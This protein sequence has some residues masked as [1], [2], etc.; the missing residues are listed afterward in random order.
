MAVDWSQFTPVEDQPAPAA[1]AVDWSKFTPVAPAFPAS[2]TD[3]FANTGNAPF[4]EAD[5]Q[6][7]NQPTQLG[8]AALQLSK[9][10]GVGMIPQLLGGL[11]GGEQVVRNALP[12]INA[13]PAAMHNPAGGLPDLYQN[14]VDPID[15]IRDVT[16]KVD[17][18]MAP[19]TKAGEIAAVPVDL[20]GRALQYAGEKT[21]SGTESLAKMFGASP[22][23]AA[24]FGAAGD[25]IAQLAAPLLLHAGLKGAKGIATNLRDANAVTRGGNAGIGGDLSTLPPA[26]TPPAPAQ[27]AEATLAKDVTDT[28]KTVAEAANVARG[29][30]P[31]QPPVAPVANGVPGPQAPT[32]AA[33]A[34]PDAAAAAQGAVA[35][36]PGA[37]LH[38]WTPVD[39]NAAVPLAGGIS[40]DAAGPRVVIDKRM[41]ATIHVEHE[42]KTVPVDAHEAVGV[43]ERTEYPLMHL[44]GPMTEADIAAL[45]Q[46]TGAD[47]KPEVVEKLKKGESLDYAQAHDIATGAE[48]AHIST[49][50]GIPPEKYQSALAEGIKTAREQAPSEEIPENLDRKPYEDDGKEHLLP[51]EQKVA[52]D[53]PKP[54]E[55]G[56][57]ITQRFEQKL[58]DYPAAKAEYAAHPETDG[59]SV[60]NTDI[61]RELSSDYVKDRTKSA[62]VHEP[63]SAFT[64]RLYADK[65]AEPTPAGKDREVLFTAGGTGAGKSTGLDSL[66]AA[67]EKPEIVYDTNMNKAESAVQK[68]DQALAAGRTVKI[69][70]TYRDPVEALRQGALKRAMRQEGEF[71]SGRSV[72]LDEHAKTHVGAAKVI[73]E[74]SEKYKDDKRVT[75][76]YL[77]NSRGKGNAA[78]VPLDKL[79]NVNENGLHEALAKTRDEAHAAGEISDAV[80][81]G[82]GGELPSGLRDEV[83]GALQ[84]Q[85]EAAQPGREESRVTPPQGPE[86]RASTP[87]DDA[88]ADGSPK[89]PSDGAPRSAPVESK[90]PEGI[91]IANKPTNADRLARGVEELVS[92]HGTTHAEVFKKA[93]DAAKTDSL[94]GQRVASEIMDGRRGVTREDVADLLVDRVRI[95][96][97]YDSAMKN[98][99]AATAR[100]D[101]GGRAAAMVHLDLL[102]EQLELNEQASRKAGTEASWALSSRRMIAQKD[103]T[104]ANQM[105]QAEIAAGKKSLSPKDA[106]AVK[107]HVAR[108]AELEKKLAAAMEKSKPERVARE[109]KPVEQRKREVVQKKV[110]KLRDQIAQRLKAC[111]L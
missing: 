87:P 18:A 11:A 71:G 3:R 53:S 63:A 4:T 50:Y 49:K 6:A 88:R 28:A 14:Q 75:F 24:G 1:G 110:D 13:I 99:D 102:S 9:L 90:P 105:R 38:P 107:D 44:T 30:S 7:T 12:D 106:Q 65:L 80:H 67:G 83:P 52:S 76:K 47:L 86:A 21:G 42:G 43:H 81:R 64:K 109:R 5:A 48:N 22:E 70:Y 31:A 40:E 78:F 37:P 46:R 104:L 79:P 39:T 72:P 25:T 74:L 85:G 61:A 77:D 55:N 26:E 17:T 8:D 45:A 62:D 34:T 95:S 19:Q 60:I 111:P 33:A 101:E 97:E 91:S 27:A 51:D 66:K 16:E 103:Y 68:I 58:A 2:I 92:E 82:F 108:I 23:T 59:G 89:S 32:P 84:R 100:N 10:F 56:N 93:V 15:R 20:A 36:A 41:P 94:R 54:L 96:N 57:P 29:E 69:L 35:P 98:F 73:R